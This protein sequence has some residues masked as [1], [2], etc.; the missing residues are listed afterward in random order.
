[1][2][3]GIIGLDRDGPFVAGGGVIQPPPFLVRDAKAA[4]RLGKFGLKDEGLV[5]TDNG[6]FKLFQFLE[7]IAEVIVRLGKI[8]RQDEGLLVTPDRLIE[9]PL[10]AQKNAQ[11]II[12]G[13]ELRIDGDGLPEGFYGFI[14]FALSGKPFTPGAVV[15]GL[16]AHAHP[17][18]CP[19][20]IPRDHSD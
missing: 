1:M 15:G 9:L 4:V 3:P 5:V 16:V 18:S 10:H 13:G 12:G 6:I 11:I 7:R 17:L 8:G 2:R 20:R 14:D 19:L